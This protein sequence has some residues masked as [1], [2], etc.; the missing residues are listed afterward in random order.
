MA[1]IEASEAGGTASEV[2]AWVGAKVPGV[3]DDV[4]FGAKSGNVTIAASIEWK[5]LSSV[6]GY[7]KT[8]TQNAGQTLKVKGKNAGGFALEWLG[9]TYSAANGVELKLTSGEAVKVAAKNMAVASL[10]IEVKTKITLTEAFS[11]R[12][13]TLTEGS[14]ITAG[15]EWTSESF[16]SSNVNTREL[17]IEN[18]IVKLTGLATVWTTS[19]ATNMTLVTTGSTIEVTNTAATARN[20]VPSTAG[21][22]KF[23]T[24]VLVGSANTPVHKIG[25]GCSIEFLKFTDEQKCRLEVTSGKT[26]T[27]TKLRAK[28]ASGKVITI[29]GSAPGTAFTIA[30]GGTETISCDWLSIKDSHAPATKWFAGANSVSTSGNEGWKFTAAAWVG[31][32]S[33]GQAQSA[34]LT[35]Q[36]TSARTLTATQAQVATKTRVLARVM[37]LAQG[38]SAVATKSAATGR[39]LSVTQAQVLSLARVPSRSLAATQ[40]QAATMT[41]SA[42]TVRTLTTTQAQASTKRVDLTRVVS[43]AQAQ[44]VARTTSIARSLSLSQGSTATHEKATGRTLSVGQAQTVARANSLARNLALSQSSQLVLG[45]AP[46]RT[47]STSDGQAASFVRAPARTLS[48]SQAQSAAVGRALLR[49]LST[50]Q[51]QTVTNSATTG[52]T[53]S[54]AQGQA[55]ARVTGL[56]RAL[57]ATQ[58]QAMSLARSPTRHFALVQSALVALSRTLT[59]SLTAE[60]A[61]TVTITRRIGKLMAAELG[62]ATSLS[63]D[64][65]RRFTLGQSQTATLE[66]HLVVT[67]KPGKLTS[68]V[69]SGILTSDATT[70]VMTSSVEQDN[71][72]STTDSGAMASSV[73]PRLRIESSVD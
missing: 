42:A 53:L 50:T 67:F 2:G 8:L 19:T 44:A 59:R 46:E 48:I 27:I 70:G 64:V 20:F 72:T 45:R 35:H 39:T 1:V 23:A 49:T 7:A 22:Q 73:K 24:L 30:A 29:E 52:H 15:F 13:L 58:G 41:R 21:T 4:V 60:A 12:A 32:F 9:G 10:T 11:G 31:E 3:N 26:L 40:G 16:S 68:T 33:V 57:S 6:A 62:S 37:T 43:V 28:G 5:S 56:A 69:E 61:T 36:N 14:W 18:S 54:A 47:L 25:G 65:E 38:Q 51:G 71:L 55:A 34:A 17:N 66:G 63:R